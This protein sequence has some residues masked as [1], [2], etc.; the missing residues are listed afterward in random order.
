MQSV[1]KKTRS[2]PKSWKRLS[3][4]DLIS[5]HLLQQIQKAKDIWPA[6]HHSS[7]WSVMCVGV[8]QRYYKTLQKTPGGIMV[9]G[10]KSTDRFMLVKIV[11]MLMTIS[12]TKTELYSC[13]VDFIKIGE[14]KYWTATSTACCTTCTASYMS[15]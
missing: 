8:C 14:G 6:C 13:W 3:G 10:R 9:I 4:N 11:G 5:F 7:C 15:I 2:H 1:M 12:S